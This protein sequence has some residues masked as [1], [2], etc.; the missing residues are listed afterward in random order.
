M[1]DDVPSSSSREDEEERGWHLGAHPALSTIL[2]PTGGARPATAQAVADLERAEAHNRR[3]QEQQARRRERQLAHQLRQQQQEQGRRDRAQQAVRR[4]LSAAIEDID[5]RQDA[6]AQNANATLAESLGSVERSRLS[7]VQAAEA[8]HRITLQQ[9]EDSACTSRVAAEQARDMALRDIELRYTS[10]RDAVYAMYEAQ[11]A[12]AGFS[13]DD[14]RARLARRAY[15][16]SALSV[17][18]STGPVDQASPDLLAQVTGELAGVALDQAS[19][20]PQ[21]SVPQVTPSVAPRD[22]ALGSSHGEATETDDLCITVMADSDSLFN[23]MMYNGATTPPPSGNDWQSVLAVSLMLFGAALVCWCERPRTAPRDTALLSSHGSYTETDDLASREPPSKPARERQITGGRGNAGPPRHHGRYKMDEGAGRKGGGPKVD[24]TRARPPEPQ[25]SVVATADGVAVPDQLVG[26][27]AIPVAREV[28]RP[29]LMVVRPKEAFATYHNVLALRSDGDSQMG[30]WVTVLGEIIPIE[31]IMLEGEFRPGY[32]A[33]PLG[34]MRFQDGAP[35]RVAQ[36]PFQHHS[37]ADGIQGHWSFIPGLQR[38]REKFAACDMRVES[39][40]RAALNRLLQDYPHIPEAVLQA[41][42]YE[43]AKMNVTLNTLPKAFPVAMRYT[44]LPPPGEF[45]RI[46]LASSLL[47]THNLRVV[48]MGVREYVQCDLRPD[49]N[50][51]RRRDVFRVIAPSRGSL[52]TGKGASLIDGQLV[53]A[54]PDMRPIGKYIVACELGATNGRRFERAGAT[55]CNQAASLI[56]LYKCRGGTRQED[57]NFTGLQLAFVDAVM[58]FTDTALRSLG[59]LMVTGSQGYEFLRGGWRKRFP[60][61]PAP[62]HVHTVPTFQ[63]VLAEYQPPGGYWTFWYL[64]SLWARCYGEVRRVGVHTLYAASFV[65]L[66]VYDVISFRYFYGQF[67]HDKRKLRER[68][69]RM[70]LGANA[71]GD[72]V[73]CPEIKAEVKDEP[74][75]VGKPPRQYFSL[76]VPAPMYGGAWLSLAKEGMRGERVVHM[77]TFTL[78]LRF[79][80]TNRPLDMADRFDELYQRVHRPERSVT[81]DFFSDDM[82]VVSNLCGAMYWE[83]DISMCDGSN[84]FG[85][86]YVA[87][88]QLM[89]LGVPREIVHG[90]LTQCLRPFRMS[91]PANRGEYLLCHFLT[92]YLVSGTVLT[93]FVDNW[94]S[95]MIV[96]ALASAFDEGVYDVG[97]I[98][99]WVREVGYIVTI[100]VR[101]E[102]EGLTMLKRHP[103]RT[104]DGSWAAPLCLGACLR[105][106]GKITCQLDEST[107]PGSA[108]SPIEVR[109]A[110]F[111]GGV[112]S[113]WVNEP[114]EPVKT[115][116]REAFPGGAGVVLPAEL[117]KHRADGPA[118]TRPLDV[119]SLCR[120][121]NL[122]ESDY[123][124]FAHS[125]RGLQ[126]GSVL[127]SR[128]LSSIY[129][130]DY[131]L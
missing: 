56:R 91:N 102:F 118:D 74:L 5:L 72:E 107:V 50:A 119:S 86:F 45:D 28:A 48:G 84:G 15:L 79:C 126:V 106:F 63:K 37:G 98:E 116:L 70:L 8:A 39:T 43:Y 83:V 53:Y 130:Y 122:D 87:A 93:T 54:T 1:S 60:A 35:G 104:T 94:A 19:P 97:Q 123:L 41:T 58:G 52:P 44:P 25:L 68:V 17:D 108:G 11:A 23:P 59:N 66:L 6:A 12:A 22:S 67:P 113:S 85:T 131:G 16:S 114:V 29:D 40:L 34:T 69:G 124:T 18:R 33:D 129:A 121:Y 105:G 65:G 99:E 26:G 81:V 10:S 46:V 80:D 117:L 32:L 76:G 89:C 78:Y 120:R 88:T 7:S 110:Q 55:A 92:F 73:F 24:M 103:C 42:V 82:I 96:S 20:P 64:Q 4:A 57:D 101:T 62:T 51:G 100:E 30:R 90:L 3:M 47:D 109:A 128:V 95:L 61:P 27:S 115:A 127:E 36:F 2:G 21:A 49:R 14:L 125:A 13:I 9:I 111:L 31:H 38:L 75:K 71:F 112:T 77:K